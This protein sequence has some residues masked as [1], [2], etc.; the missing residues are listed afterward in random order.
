MTKIHELTDLGQSIWYD[1][2]S[3]ALLDSGE[4][5]QL[6]KQSFLKQ[7]SELYIQYQQ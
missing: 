7:H 5:D 3:R 2:I 4:F 1:N 6:L